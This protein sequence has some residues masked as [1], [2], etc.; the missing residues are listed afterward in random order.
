[1]QFLLP[2]E[3]G[4]R[5]PSAKGAAAAILLAGSLSVLC[6]EVFSGASVLWFINPA[7]WVFMFPLYL[8]HLLLFFNLA[9]LFRRTSLSSLYLWGVLFG[10]YESWITKVTWAGYMGQQPQ[11]GTVLGFAPAEFLII[12]FFWHPVMSF[13]VPLF[14]FE[15]LVM[16]RDRESP[17]LAGHAV[18]L[19]RGRRSMALLVL[20]ALTGAAFLSMNSKFDSVAALATLIGTFAIIALFRFCTIRWN[21]DRSSIFSLTL[22][23][24]GFVILLVY[25]ILLYG[26]SFLLL[27]PERIA[28]LLT[29][30]LTILFYA[31]IVLL[32]RY[33]IPVDKRAE[34]LMPDHHIIGIPD[35]LR[36]SGLAVLLVMFFCLIPQAGTAAGISFYL[37]CT[38]AGPVLAAAVVIHVIRTKRALMQH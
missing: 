31:V 33:D 10:M 7:S 25:L 32:L 9:V 3:D 38:S 5:F 19:L 13:I 18:I 6:A 30:F 2:L 17:V 8:A 35:L 12:V 11:W 34:Q 28:P 20:L 36:T 22:S 15:T 21:N 27:L 1:M 16:S 26:L 29:I 23:R 37:A 24:R 14:L 4:P